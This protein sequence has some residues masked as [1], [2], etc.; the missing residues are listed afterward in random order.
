MLIGSDFA[1]NS[2]F[3]MSELGAIYSIYF[4][5]FAIWVQISLKKRGLLENRAR[6]LVLQISSDNR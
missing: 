6:Y 5:Q 1:A 4:F 2:L 3:L